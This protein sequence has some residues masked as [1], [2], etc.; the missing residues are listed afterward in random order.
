MYMFWHWARFFRA[1]GSRLERLSR[2]LD[3]AV[4]VTPAANGGAA[5]HVESDFQPS[6][7][8][9]LFHGLIQLSLRER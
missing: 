8:H 4:V 7:I 6:N 5:T 3:W 1:I 9:P 2:V